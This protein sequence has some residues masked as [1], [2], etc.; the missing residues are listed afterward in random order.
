ML[1]KA[2]HKTRQTQN[3]KTK[4]TSNAKQK[5]KRGGG[6]RERISDIITWSPFSFHAL[7]EPFRLA[8]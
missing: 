6:G 5:N 8:K 1:N 4:H 2:I 3:N 7:E